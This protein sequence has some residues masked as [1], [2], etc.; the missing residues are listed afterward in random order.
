[1]KESIIAALMLLSLP[2]AAQVKPVNGTKQVNG[3]VLAYQTQGS[4]E[5]LIILHGG[6]GMDATY[7]HPHLDGLGQI[8][9]LISYDQRGSGKVTEQLDTLMLNVDQFVEDLEEFRKAMGLKKINLLGHSWGGLL[10][11][12]YA[13]KYPDQLDAVI[14][15]SSAGGDASVADKTRMTFMDRLSPADKESYFRM[16]SENYLATNEGISALAKIHW[17]PFVVD[18][19]KIPFIKDAFNENMPLIQRH[20]EKSLAGYDLYN[21]LSKLDIPTLIIH[22]D[23]DPI[24]MED[25][26]K[27][28]HSINGSKLVVLKDCGHFPFIEQPEKFLETVLQF[29]EPLSKSLYFYYPL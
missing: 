18:N 16:L 14:L 27:L 9:Q 25:I 19:E 17:K 4:G 24:P 29:G 6:P 10:A 12:N 20:I 8:F 3:T 2:L 7:L 28:H 1:M 5:P 23:Y 22:G 21:K 15:V 26:K 13:I 11:M